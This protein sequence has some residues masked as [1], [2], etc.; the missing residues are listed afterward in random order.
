MRYDGMGAVGGPYARASMLQGL[1]GGT[2]RHRGQREP[3]EDL[4]PTI[5]TPTRPAD[6]PSAHLCG[7]GRA[8]TSGRLDGDADRNMILGRTVV[9]PPTAWRCWRPT[10]EGAG[11]ATRSAGIARSMPTSRAADKV[12]P[13]WHRLPRTP[14]GWKFFGN[15]L[16][17]V[18]PRSAAR[19][20]MAPVPTMCARRTAC[21]G[22]FWLNLLAA[23][24]ASRS[25][26]WCARTG[27]AS[28]RHYYSRHDWG[29]Q[30]PDRARRRA[31]GRVARR[32]HAGRARLRRG[33]ASRPP[34]TSPH[35]PGR[36]FRLSSRRGVR[37]LLAD[38]SPVVFRLSG[39]GTEGCHLA[40]PCLSA[41][42]QADPAD[43]DPKPA[44]KRWRTDPHC[45]HGGRYSRTLSGRPP[46]PS[47]D[48]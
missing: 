44:K 24:A 2:G 32:A 35:R 46:L 28:G 6:E 29:R 20:A 5:P 1:L 33:L 45:R 4:R 16:D 15:L 31:D 23:T 42:R 38:G 39:T 26:P 13:A 30:H 11:L 9:T 19:K 25:S 22:L 48:T 17:A 8:R 34:T 3:L 10:P 43:H 21:G 18:R 37:L 7:A 41:S 40:R 14:T 27:R 12:A 36:R 47:P